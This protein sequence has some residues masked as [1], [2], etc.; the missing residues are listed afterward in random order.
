MFGGG[1]LKKKKVRVQVPKLVREI[2]ERDSAHFNITRE[3]LC[4]LIILKVGYRSKFDLAKELCNL[5]KVYLQFNLNS[6][7]LNFYLDI[8]K[9]N[10]NTNESEVI[11][12]ILLTY[13]NLNSFLRE[14]ILFEE[15]LAYFEYLKKSEDS[16]KVVVGDRI[17]EEKVIRIFPCPKTHYIRVAFEKHEDYLSRLKVT[18]Y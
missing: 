10:G 1:V 16:V 15:Q 9:S 13:I 11:R 7:C 6:Q 14:K 17:M 2:L 18:K 4:N 12:S 3:K 5:E 8:L